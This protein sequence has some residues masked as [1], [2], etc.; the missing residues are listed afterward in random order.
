VA[1]MSSAPSASQDWPTPRPSN[2]MNFAR[3]SVVLLIGIGVTLAWQSYGD[4]AM[5]IVRTKAPSLAWLL[6]VS[7]AKPA[8]Q[9]SNAAAAS[10]PQL[11]QQLEVGLVQQLMLGLGAVRRSVEQVAI[12]VDQL[13]AKQEQLAA[14]QDQMAQ[15]IATLQSVEQEISK[16]LSS[17]AVAPRKPPQP[18]A[19]SSAT[20]PPTEPPT[21]PQ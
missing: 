1:T 5:Q 21:D 4:E 16:K 14:K 19:Q 15:N 6:P 11:A 18:A 10:S 9:W 2:I 12:K 20:P 3:Y 8:D 7:T 17:R 13:A